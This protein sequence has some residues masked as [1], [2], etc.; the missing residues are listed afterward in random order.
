MA[1]TESREKKDR[2]RPW[3]KAAT[4]A[5]ILVAGR[6]VVERSGTEALTLSAVG[7]EAGLAPTTVFAYFRNKADL[8]LAI[9]SDDLAQF[10]RWMGAREQGGAPTADELANDTSSQAVDTSGPRL[11]LVADTGVSFDAS[12]SLPALEPVVQSE[13]IA[14]SA[15]DE[16]AKLQEAVARLEARPVDA[17]LERRLRELERGFAAFE[18]KQAS[19]EQ[20]SAQQPAFEESIRG[21][22]ARLDALES[23]VAQTTDE[24]LP[25]LGERLNASEDHKRQALSDIQAV[26]G[27]ITNRLDALENAAFAVAPTFF[28]S[29]TNDDVSAPQ[30]SAAAEAISQPVQEAAEKT[31]S[32]NASGST[33]LSDARKSAREAQLRADLA[34]PPATASHRTTRRALYW[35]A[36]GLAVLVAL[37]WTGVFVK[38]RELAAQPTG[39]QVYANTVPTVAH[40]NSSRRDA[41]LGLLNSARAGDPKAQLVI[42]LNL[43]AGPQHNDAVAAKWLSSAA[44]QGNA[45][46][47]LKLAALYRAGRG[48]APDA[49]QAFRWYELAASAHNCDAMYDVAVAYAE[50]WGTPKDYSAAARWFAKAASLGLTD[51][52]FNLGVMYERGLGVPLSLADAYKWYLVAAAQGDRQAA[53]RVNAL[54]PQLDSSDL[55]AA[56]ESAATFK[57]APRDP[58]ANEIPQTSPI[59]AG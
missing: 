20:E 48:V 3:Q 16:I 50:G 43:L 26:H 59:S 56:E 14:R 13:G 54:K 31:V 4:R 18:A 32:Q 22:M 6:R 44:K 2:S 49:T 52:Q 38:A 29:Q 7:R 24:G 27:R 39:T 10:A 28:P 8:F 57:P 55:A 42:G 30:A 34:T 19:A 36:G 11:R 25:R 17:W 35:I 5:A 21:L 40:K 51:S 41:S 15:A 1:E 46:A 12:E 58:D 47:A 23:K 45:L 53:L 37:I 33:F 9:V